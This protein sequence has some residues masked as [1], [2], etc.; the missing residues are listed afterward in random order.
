MQLLA[1]NWRYQL[2][3]LRAEVAGLVTNDWPS[4]VFVYVG[5]D[6]LVMV[7]ST[8]TLEGCRAEVS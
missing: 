2:V 1:L 4:C 5:F 7:L 3:V 8:M 6:V